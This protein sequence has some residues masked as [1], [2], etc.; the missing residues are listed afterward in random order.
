MDMQRKTQSY[1]S[2]GLFITYL[3]IAY[4]CGAVI[5]A[6]G[7]FKRAELQ[8]INQRFEARSWLNWNSESLA[9]LNPFVL[10]AYHQ[11]HEIPKRLWAWDY[12]LSWLIEKNH[13]KIK[14][15]FV[16][17]E[18]QLEDEPPPEAA[19]VNPWM[20]PL[21]KWPVSR[22]SVAD[23]I[24]FLARSNV[25]MIILDNDFPQYSPDDSHL[26]LSIHKCANGTTSGYP[27]P[28]LMARTINRSSA[29][30]LVKVEVP[31]APNGVLSQLKKLEPDVDV[32]EK[33][34]GSTGVWLDQDQVVR[35][36][37]TRIQGQ[38]GADY[39]SIAVKALAR[40]GEKLPDA[41]PNP[42]IIDYAGPPN[43]ELYP[44]RPYTYLLD[45]ERQKE[46]TLP[47]GKTEDV[48]L[49]DAVVI[50]G[51]GVL[52][53]YST[54]T[55][56]FG[57]N[58]MSGPEILANAI[59]T[60]SRQSWPTSL[61]GIAAINWIFLNALV[62]AAILAFCRS[63][64]TKE[65]IRKNEFILSGYTTKNLLTDLLVLIFTIVLS[66]FTACIMFAWLK[67][68]VPVISTL[69]ALTFGTVG[70]VAFEREKDRLE[71]MRLRVQTAEEK[72][73]MM[74]EIHRV[75]LKAQA[76]HAEAREYLKEREQRLEFL[77]KINHD[78]RGPVGV[79]NWTIMRLQ[80]EGLQSASAP[81]KLERLA[82]SSDRLSALL[83]ELMHSYEDKPRADTDENSSMTD[84]NDIALECCKLQSSLA[85][86]RQSTI[87]CNLSSAAN[88]RVR[89]LEISRCIDNLI[90][91]A[92]LHNKSGTHVSVSVQPGTDRHAI[93]VGDN[94]K[95]I[96]AA[97]LSHIF[98]AGYRVKKNMD[99]HKDGQGLGLHIVKTL[100]EESG[101]EVSV[102]STVGEG[103]KFIIS[104]P[105]KAISDQ[106]QLG[107]TSEELEAKTEVYA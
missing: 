42:L 95:G 68:I 94:G 22:A 8:T 26:A 66:T 86:E 89:S 25:K 104:L 40:L 88:V 27:I 79:L 7:I 59:D 72:L 47:S 67:L 15:K 65:S 28:V 102:E 31:T 85:E 46:M 64:A 1:S 17:F 24:D 6:S 3:V 10:F 44:V 56:N 60:I 97:D 74:Q 16:I 57:C 53:V 90:R 96:A 11:K 12:T 107:S 45:P 71:T 14:H 35:S 41:I 77:H 2:Y 100:I 81:Q 91:N 5:E 48:T 63:R 84:L 13:P 29:S 23:S 30:N 78:L 36:L 87:S 51:D 19:E 99:S 50:L 69:V 80:K 39:E 32:V 73:E 83:D 75:E 105:A 38:Q 21:L 37:A 20:K 70:A 101:G 92:L 52:D 43:S 103:T 106:Q 61:T 55:T 54:S 58:F 18:H 34:T 33:Y 9:R 76:A 93:T 49:K 98:D 62:G 4:V 82:N